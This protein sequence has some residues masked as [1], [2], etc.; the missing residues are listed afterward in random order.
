MKTSRSTLPSV[1]QRFFCEYL[2]QQ[3]QVSAHTVSSYRD[4]LRLL[5]SFLHARLNKQPACLQIED[6]N[7]QNIA[8]F[9]DYCESER[10]NSART[11]NTR[12]AAIRSF[13]RFALRCE[14]ESLIQLQG[15]MAIPFKKYAKQVLGYLTP[16]EMAA[17]LDVLQTDRWSD[18][19]D[20]L[21]FTVMYGTGARVSEILAA[22]VGDLGSNGTNRLTLHGKGRKDRIVPLMKQTAKMLR[23]WVRDNGLNADSPLLPNARR[24]PMTRSAVEKRLARTVKAAVKSC[25]SLKGKNV[26]P[27]TIRHTTAMH[28]LQ[29][30]TALTVIALWLGHED[31]S[32]THIYMTSD[33]Q[34]KEKALNALQDPPA[35][36][37]RFRPGDRLLQFLDSL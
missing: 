10:G 12:L 30:G 3:R 29:S 34:M 7:A 4:T 25:P 28:L 18:R 6:L 20:R 14:P 22:R 9:L 21:L 1:L 19:R 33:I 36:R 27:H 15:A 13:T 31:L 32:T 5:L 35:Q 16:K 26:T 23:D 8:A 2:I 17:I 37:R 24:L 11:R